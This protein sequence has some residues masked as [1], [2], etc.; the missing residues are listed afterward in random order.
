MQ[1]TPLR[2]CFT[3][4][5]LFGLFVT[6]SPQCKR[7]SY[8]EL[9]VKIMNIPGSNI[10]SGRILKND[11]SGPNVIGT[12]FVI[13]GAIQVREF[14]VDFCHNNGI[15]YAN[16]EMV[17]WRKDALHRFERSDG[18]TIIAYAE[19]LCEIHICDFIRDAMIGAYYKL[20]SIIDLFKRDVSIS[21]S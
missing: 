2:S 19:P 11:P 8:M 12:W 7:F 14:G 4:P 17:R 1:T 9:Y 16:T 20:L 13:D 18:P 10:N 3:T 21:I 6:D 5:L 15:Q